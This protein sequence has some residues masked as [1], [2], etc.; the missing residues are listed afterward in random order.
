M[1]TYT[2]KEFAEMTGKSLKLIE[3]YCSRGRVIKNEDKKIDTKEPNNYSF[4]MSNKVEGVQ[5]VEA[6]KI[7]KDLQKKPLEKQPEQPEQTKD[8]KQISANDPDYLKPVTG[9][10]SIDDLNMYRANQ[11]IENTKTAILKREILEGKY[12]LKD[13]TIQIVSGIMKRSKS[14]DLTS[15]EIIIKK[16]L[17]K[18][19]APSELK[20]AAINDIRLLSNKNSEALKIE[21][22]NEF[23]K[24]VDNES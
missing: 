16:Y 15:A 2:V 21:L 20:V 24:L 18:M 9:Y 12:V 19:D 6:P 23:E 8:K 22:I 3:A 7:I 14:S 11:I 4:L 17:D 1:A 5:A 13:K 10:C